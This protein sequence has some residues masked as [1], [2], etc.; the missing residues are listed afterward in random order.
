[1]K[2]WRERLSS[3]KQDQRLRYLVVG[4]GNTLWGYLCANILYYTLIS[5]LHLLVIGIIANIFSI[6]FSFFTYK[7]LVFRTKGNWLREY[8]RCYVVYGVGGILATLAMWGLVD[9]LHIPF[10]LAQ[11]LVMGLVVVFSYFGHSRF[12]FAK[13]DN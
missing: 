2:K 6:S 1:M 3:L 9:G 11:G 8:L 5:H 7:T 4:G 10:W 13:K 12:S